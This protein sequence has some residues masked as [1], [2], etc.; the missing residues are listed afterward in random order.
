MRTTFSWMEHFYESLGWK[1]CAGGAVPVLLWWK[2]F[3]T[4]K[5][6]LNVYANQLLRTSDRLAGGQ[7]DRN[8]NFW[9][10]HTGNPISLSRFLTDDLMT[11]S[12]AEVLWRKLGTKDCVR[13]MLKD[14]LDE[15][16]RGRLFAVKVRSQNDRKIFAEKVQNQREPTPFGCV[17][18]SAM[19]LL[20]IKLW[21]QLKPKK[22]CSSRSF[23]LQLLGIQKRSAP[24]HWNYSESFI[25]L[26]LV[27]RRLLASKN[28][29]FSRNSLSRSI[30]SCW[31]ILQALQ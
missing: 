14:L 4:K 10:G 23:F 19:C 17:T 30:F 22:R 1:W 28:S 26:F 8:S 2:A 24:T 25:A 18:S 20:L 7:T 13:K 3:L 21:W 16:W 11:A 31:Q 12:A 15:F 6:I 5:I 9:I 27:A 29:K